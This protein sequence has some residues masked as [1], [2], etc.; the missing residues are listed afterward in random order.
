MEGIF[1]AYVL[2]PLDKKFIFE[3]VTRVRTR[4]FRVTSTVQQAKENSE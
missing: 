4:N 1:D 2:W 3:L